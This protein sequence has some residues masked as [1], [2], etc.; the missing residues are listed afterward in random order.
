MT[1]KMHYSLHYG[2]LQQLTLVQSV[3][4]W[5]VFHIERQLVSLNWVHSPS[6]T[7]VTEAFDLRLHQLLISLEFDMSFR[8][9]SSRNSRTSK[10][11]YKHHKEHI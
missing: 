3:S 1:E 2:S 10:I 9:Y 7:I 5:M 8:L 11:C 4:T 6:V